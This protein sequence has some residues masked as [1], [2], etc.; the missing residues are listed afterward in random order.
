MFQVGESVRLNA[1]GQASMRRV[2]HHGPKAM[3]FYLGIHTVRSSDDADTWLHYPV[4]VDIETADSISYDR[5]FCCMTI[6]LER[7]DV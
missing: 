2:R 7:V 3:A 4:G 1:R 5:T 6:H